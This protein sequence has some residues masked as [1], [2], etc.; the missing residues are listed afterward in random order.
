MKKIILLFPV[1]GLMFNLQAQLSGTYTVDGNSPTKKLNFN[2]INDAMN[3]LRY[4][5]IEGDVTIS[6]KDA[7][8]FQPLV[9][10]GVSNE[11]GYNVHF[12]SEGE[13]AQFTN[14]GLSLLVSNSSNVS[15]SNIKFN[16]IST[17]MSN[18]VMLTNSSEIV[19]E[20]NEFYTS[21]KDAN[22]KNI[23]SISS[24]SDKN[25]IKANSFKG[26]GGITVE[27]L[28]NNNQ[29]IGN[30][31]Y[32]HA[33]GIEVLSAL[34]TR[35]EG[36]TLKAMNKQTSKGILIDGF[37]GELNIASNA[38]LNVHQG[39]AQEV[40]FRPSNQ[41]VSGN[42]V[43]NVIEST[44]NTVALNN[45]VSDLKIAFNTMSS[46]EAS[47]IVIKEEIKNSIDNVTLLAN[48]LINE[49]EVA[50][51]YVANAKNLATTDYNNIYNEGGKF[52]A[53][54][55]AVEVSS[56]ED[57]KSNMSADNTISADPIFIQ[58]GDKQYLLSDMSP[59]IDAGPDAFDIGV[60][61]DFD[62]DERG[63]ITEIGADEFNKF[64]FDE[65][66]NQIQLAQKK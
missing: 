33:T 10:E 60:L 27:R 61:A 9:V 18:M 3:A 41:K 5:G 36:N 57:W 37:V 50:I 55:G 44:G 39:I 48:N 45:N 40:I 46:K 19:I 26:S 47:V 4:E 25:T 38:I 13:K 2:S 31:M 58:N 29:I 32:F 7:E 34:N 66:L 49:D 24:S 30:Q 11:L 1:L 17:E 42:I 43:N 65:I 12:T 59:C 20:E 8:Y 15:F 14:D 62:G 52:S 56:L 22:F 28:S 53:K 35:I 63:E 54:V 6:F 16:A 64:A 21:E 51:I 23:L